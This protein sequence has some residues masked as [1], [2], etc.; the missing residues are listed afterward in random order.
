MPLEAPW[1][2]GQVER[3]GGLW[4]QLMTKVAQE[5]QIQ[6]LQDM[7]TAT[8]IVTQIRN[9]HPRAMAMPRTSGYLACPKSGS[10]DP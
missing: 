5:S 1:K 9:A 8:T 6:G 4:K 10:P 7:I 3:A 2:Q